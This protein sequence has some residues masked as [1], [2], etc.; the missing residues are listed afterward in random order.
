MQG[1]VE[2]LKQY[3]QPA[4][5]QL[6]PCSCSQTPL[7]VQVLYWAT[8][9]LIQGGMGKDPSRRTAA[10]I[11]EL[12][13]K[14]ERLRAR[15]AATIVEHRSL[16]AAESGAPPR[17]TDRI[18][19][20]PANQLCEPRMS[21]PGAAQVQLNLQILSLPEGSVAPAHHDQGDQAERWIQAEANDSQEGSADMSEDSQVSGE[22]NQAEVEEE[23]NEGEGED[24]EDDNKDDDEDDDD[25]GMGGSEE[26]SG[27][28]DVDDGE[29]D[30][31]SADNRGAG[32]GGTD[33]GAGSG[34]KEGDRS[35]AQKRPG[36]GR[37][38]SKAPKQPRKQ[39]PE[40]EHIEELRPVRPLVCGEQPFSSRLQA[41]GASGA[42][43]DLVCAVPL[44][45]VSSDSLK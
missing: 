18:H 22:D 21:D 12:Q 36:S 24:G 20:D 5:C 9:Q 25:R 4:C 23:E 19:V 28:K 32:Q 43:Q 40:T 44:I 27:R 42:E 34:F 39:Q 14:G 45:E 11:D 29:D 33:T 38:P 2:S 16:E 15:I 37:G 17:A 3:A 8:I 30:G 13:K 6:L 7:V 26:S 31:A 35:E 41:G 1:T 10:E